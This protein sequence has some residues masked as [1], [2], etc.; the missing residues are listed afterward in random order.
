M[1]GGMIRGMICVPW[2]WG[3]GGGGDASA[4]RYIPAVRREPEVVNLSPIS[5]SVAEPGSPEYDDPASI[6][7]FPTSRIGTRELEYNSRQFFQMT[8][9]HCFQ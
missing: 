4:I 5:P 9:S 1:R 3:S 8:P 6:S 2:V 7:R